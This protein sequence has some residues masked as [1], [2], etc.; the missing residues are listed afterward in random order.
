MPRYSDQLINEVIAENDIVDYISQYVRL[1]QSGRD[2]SG[3]CPFHKEKSPS[4]HVNRDKQV[5]HCFG[6][7]AGGGLMQFVMR[8]EG[9]DFVEALKLLADRAGIVLPE[10]GDVARDDAKYRQKQRIYEINKL[11]ARFF[12]DTLTKSPEG[13]VGLEY[14]KTRQIHPQTITKYGLGYAPDKYDALLGYLRSKGYTDREL[15]DAQVIGEKNGKIFDFFRGRV[16]FPIIDLRGNVIGFGGRVLTDAKPKY[17]N[18]TSSPVFDKGRNLFSLN[19]AKKSNSNKLI[20]C[21]GYM[22]VISVYQAG[23]TN[24]V[25]TLGT[26]LTENQAKLLMKYCREILICYDSDDAGQTATRRAIDIINSVGG[27]ARVIE[28]QGAKDPDE[29]IK[30]NGV[31]MFRN[32]VDNAPSSSDYLVKS[33]RRNYNLDTE[34]GKIGYVSAAVDSLKGVQDDIEVDAYIKRIS[35]ES[36]ISVDAIYAEYKKKAVA[37][38]KEKDRVVR[39]PQ[40]SVLQAHKRNGTKLEEAEILLLSL[41]SKSKKLYKLISSEMQIGDYSTD[42][43]KML[44]E[45]I[46]NSFENGATPDSTAIMNKVDED[47]LQTVS[48]VFCLDEQYQDSDNAA[49]ELINTIK[50][51]KI[52]QMLE[53][54]T[55]PAKIVELIKMRDKLGRKM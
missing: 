20:L 10:E 19:L 1:K 52:E 31:V 24:V 11:A 14:F 30:L 22:D 54:E 28:M 46:Y 42:T 29:Y 44:A 16:I 43:L 32:L 25:A 15:L 33:A 2:F 55:N 17:L 40:I 48:K 35:K 38:K 53:G 37:Y 18:T 12:Y 6:C 3:L 45:Y 49:M 8:I 51:E 7:G 50:K 41:C 9:L 36:G 21:E 39:V 5:F 4:F 23:I 13:R 34:D 47:E 27:K 26:A